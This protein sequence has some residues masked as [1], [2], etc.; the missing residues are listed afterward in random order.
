MSNCNERERYRERTR[1]RLADAGKLGK[2][3]P[4]TELRK[5]DVVKTAP[6]VGLHSY[7]LDGMTGKVLSL[8][9][10]NVKLHVDYQPAPNG[11]VYP[12][13]HRVPV[14][15]VD[16]VERDGFVCEVVSA[17]TPREGERT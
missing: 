1:T 11:P 10:V 14:G 17:A 15:H 2:P 8:G 4:C 12:Q 16:W 9:R 3:V 7:G 5:G 6:R 13:E